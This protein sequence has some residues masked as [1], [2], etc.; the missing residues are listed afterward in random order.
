MSPA[1]TSGRAPL[2]PRVGIPWRTSQ[3]EAARSHP[4][5][6]NYEDAVRRAGGEPVVL[7]LSDPLALD[8]ALPTL[9]AFVLPGSPSVVAPAGYAALNRGLSQPPDFAREAT[10]PAILKRAFAQQTPRLVICR[11]CPLP[12]VYSF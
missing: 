6:K 10:E 7:T 5:I 12:D 8:R 9:D 4:K 11:F 1:M 3:E 2:R